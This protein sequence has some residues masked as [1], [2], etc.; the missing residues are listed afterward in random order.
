MLVKMSVAIFDGL[1]MLGLLEP[2]VITPGFMLSPFSM[3]K[4][5]IC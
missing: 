5:L 3:A 2:S 1:K 4:N